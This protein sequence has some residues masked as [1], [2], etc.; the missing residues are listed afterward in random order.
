[1][2]RQTQGKHIQS[3]TDKRGLPAVQQSTQ[4]GLKR[5]PGPT[6]AFFPKQA[7]L[8]WGGGELGLHPKGR[9]IGGS[10]GY[11]NLLGMLPIPTAGVDIGGPNKGFMAGVMPDLES[12]IGVSPYIGARWNHPRKS[13]L[14]RQFPRGVPE[15]IYDKLRGRT[16]QDAI[17]KSYPDEFEEPEAEAPVDGDGKE[18]PVFGDADPE[19]LAAFDKEM[20]E[21][22]PDWYEYR[23]ARANNDPEADYYNEL[24]KK[25]DGDGDGKV[26]DGKETEKE[27]ASA[28]GVKLAMTKIGPA[29]MIHRMGSSKSQRDKDEA[30][31][32]LRQTV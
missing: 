29:S 15:V 32:K 8:A 5:R 22:Q 6:N 7:F 18:R 30:Q 1:M 13:G 19:E 27:K 14:T 31:Q 25:K 2:S 24:F 12:E 10:V 11:T 3:N 21:S 20:L 26:N 9:G 17:R 23:A 4:E 16:K 28:F